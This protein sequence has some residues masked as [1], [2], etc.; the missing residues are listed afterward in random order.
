M[1][2]KNGDQD[3]TILSVAD[4]GSETGIE[5]VRGQGEVRY[6]CQIDGLVYYVT[7]SDNL[8][9]GALHSYNLE[10]HVKRQYR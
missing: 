2:R 10:N 9:Q 3:Y 5:D 1:T 8:E 7:Y 4:D 6:T